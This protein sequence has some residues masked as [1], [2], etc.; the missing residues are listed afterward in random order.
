TALDLMMRSSAVAARA[1]DAS[2]T[3]PRLS[4]VYKDAIY[5]L[6]P[7]RIDRLPYLR[8]QSGFFRHLLRS[9]IS[10]R[11]RATGSTS[12]FSITYGTEGPL[13]GIPVAATYQP[14]WWFKVE[15]ELDE[16]QD[17]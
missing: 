12:E 5:D 6:I 11:N 1:S 8:A 10:V 7:R 9:E 14:T 13:S 16:D 2:P 3:S 17:V 15:L 4:Y